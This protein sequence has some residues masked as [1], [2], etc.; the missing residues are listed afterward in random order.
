VPLA[1]VHRRLGELDEAERVIQEGLERHP[2][3]ASGHVVAGRIYLDRGENDQAEQAFGRA[4]D[5]DSRNVEALRSLG[6]LLRER[7][8]A[9]GCLQLFR[10]LQEEQ[11][12]N[13]S[14][15]E[16]I[17]ALECRVASSAVSGETDEFDCGQG[18]WAWLSEAEIASGL[19]WD[20][21]TLQSDA[22]VGAPPASRPEPEPE[23]ETGPREIPSTRTL[24]E[25]YL[26]Q[27][28]LERAEEVFE[29]LL[30][31]RPGDDGIRAR[32]AEINARRSAGSN[33]P[34]VSVRDLAPEDPLPIESLAPDESLALESEMPGGPLLIE[35]L[36]PDEIVPI[37][38]LAPDR[39]RTLDAGAAAPPPGNRILDEFKL[40]LDHLS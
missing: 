19:D 37:D 20:A 13:K 24:G 26:R 5:L 27:G 9:S 7:G 23:L 34:V 1:E 2:E 3:L 40:W 14:V 6:K 8:D 28:M 35:A 38:S 16:Q 18:P 4:L 31:R 12:W 32:L 29:E 11:P 39:T 10:R 15:D 22:S 25:I 21:A 36:A 30:G 17:R 33:E